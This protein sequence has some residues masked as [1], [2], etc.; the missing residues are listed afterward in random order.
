MIISNSN[1]INNNYYNYQLDK[2][3]LSHNTLHFQTVFI[4][5]LDMMGGGI[6]QITMS[7]YNPIRKR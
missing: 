1:T 3:A 5:K 4:G 6:A 7:P 2:D